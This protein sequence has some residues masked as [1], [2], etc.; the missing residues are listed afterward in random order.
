MCR[1]QNGTETC[2]KVH[3]G[4]KKGKN[5][6]FEN[7]GF[8]P[9]SRRGRVGVDTGS[10]RRALDGIYAKDFRFYQEN[11]EVSPLLLSNINFY[12][13]KKKPHKTKQKTKAKKKIHNLRKTNGGSY[14]DIND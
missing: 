3:R 2:A 1:K 4:K 8:T 13:T 9:T 5:R 12:L 7:K 14:R 10:A 6:D 11:S